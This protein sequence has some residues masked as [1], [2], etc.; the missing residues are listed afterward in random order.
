MNTDETGWQV[1]G[2]TFRLWCLTSKDAVYYLINPIRG[3]SVLKKLFRS[4]R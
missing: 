1:Q 4:V 3:S 2:Q